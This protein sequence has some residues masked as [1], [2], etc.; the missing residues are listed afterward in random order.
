M[1]VPPAAGFGLRVRGYPRPRPCARACPRNGQ[2]SRLADGP[3]ISACAQPAI[4][5][6][7]WPCCC[8]Q[9]D[10]SPV[11]LNCTTDRGRSLSGS[12]RSRARISNLVRFLSWCLCVRSL[13]ARE[14]HQG[15]VF[16]TGHVSSN[17]WKSSNPIVKCRQLG[18]VRLGAGKEIESKVVENIKR[19]HVSH[20]GR[21]THKKVIVAL[22]VVNEGRGQGWASQTNLPSLKLSL[23][24]LIRLE[25]K[26]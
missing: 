20:G 15:R 3:G 13:K 5:Q 2:Y 6:Q 23:V 26:V 16:L 8:A 25:P 11:A 10:Y 12:H 24:C 14:C 21:V 18:E 7:R 22:R 9:S 4:S 1:L 19:S 17:V